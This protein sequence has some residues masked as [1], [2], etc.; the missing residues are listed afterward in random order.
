MSKFNLFI[1]YPVQ[2]DINRTSSVDTLNLNW[3]FNFSYDCSNTF[4]L[5]TAPDFENL[6]EFI[7][8]CFVAAQLWWNFESMQEKHCSLRTYS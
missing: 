3:S 2:M 7:K 4:T 5:I 8:N 6:Q 1:N